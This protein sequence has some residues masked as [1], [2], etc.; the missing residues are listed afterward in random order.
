MTTW[1]QILNDMVEF[2]IKKFERAQLLTPLIPPEAV[3]KLETSHSPREIKREA[4]KIVEPAVECMK[5]SK[6]PRW[7]IKMEEKTERNI[8]RDRMNSA[9]ER[10]RECKLIRPTDSFL[11]HKQETACTFAVEELRDMIHVLW[12]TRLALADGCPVPNVSLDEADTR[13]ATTLKD[14]DLA[15]NLDMVKRTVAHNKEWLREKLERR[16]DSQLAT[17]RRTL[18]D[19]M[20]ELRK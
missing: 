20:E 9:L 18:E 2:Y 17:M 11:E 8:I 6:H 15:R 3:K 1:M 16:K 7:L 10:I 14:L 12:T 19:R 5:K 13:I 4:V